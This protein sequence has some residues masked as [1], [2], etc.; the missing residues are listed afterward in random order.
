M[1]STAERDDDMASMQ[2]VH[3][4]LFELDG[5]LGEL[6]ESDAVDS[7]SSHVQ[8]IVK[9]YGDLKQH[10]REGMARIPESDR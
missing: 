9:R 6:L 3:D 8:S 7:E 4:F 2:T 5:L 10:F 1:K